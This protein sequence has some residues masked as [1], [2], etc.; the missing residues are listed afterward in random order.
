M[1]EAN[2]HHVVN[3]HEFLER[4]GAECGPQLAVEFVTLF[5]LCECGACFVFETGFFLGSLGEAGV[6]DVEF[7]HGE[8]VQSCFV[9]RELFAEV[10]HDELTE[11]CA[12]V[13]QV[14]DAFDFV[15]GSLV[16]AGERVT[17]H[18]GA[19]MVEGEFLTDVRGAVVDADNLAI[20]C[21]VAVFQTLG[22]DFVEGRL[23][24][25]SAVDEEVEVTVHG[26][27]F[28]KTCRELNLGG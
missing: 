19:Q 20:R 10:H 5:E 26:F 27:N 6:K 7:L 28:R 22:G 11:C 24:E 25:E 4:C 8:G 2:A 18:G 15:T 16:N 9:G 17:N 14:V 3:A 21:G 23:G 1:V 12:P 13:A